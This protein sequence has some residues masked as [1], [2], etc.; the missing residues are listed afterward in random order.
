MAFTSTFFIRCFCCCTWSNRMGSMGF[1]ADRMMLRWGRPPEVGTARLTMKVE[2]SVLGR[3]FGLGCRLLDMRLLVM[4][5]V[6]RPAL[7][8]AMIQGGK[9]AKVQPWSTSEG[10]ID[11][12]K[13]LTMLREFAQYT[14]K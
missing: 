14:L 7:L 5:R 4:A 11:V 12:S 13:N 2:T 3:F 8:G 9:M 1:D 6:R 10:I